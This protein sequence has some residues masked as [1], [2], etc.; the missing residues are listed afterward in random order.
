MER[1]Y[2][3]N[4]KGHWARDY[5]GRL[6]CSPD[7]DFVESLAAKTYP[8]HTVVE[9][10]L[11]VAPDKMVMIILVDAIRELTKAVSGAK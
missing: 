11:E 6:I 7:R 10:A 2:G 8:G 9:M 4:R 5:V 1:L 3:I